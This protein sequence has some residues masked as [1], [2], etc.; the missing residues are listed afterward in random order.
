[1]SLSAVT[2]M[3][4]LKNTKVVKSWIEDYG[5]KA[6]RTR[7]ISEKWERGKEVDLRQYIIRMNHLMDWLEKNQDRWDSRR[8]PPYGLGIEPQWLVQKRARDEKSTPL[9]RFWTDYE[10]QYLAMQVGRGIPY[11]Q[12]AKDL[13][14][15]LKSVKSKGHELGLVSG[16]GF[17]KKTA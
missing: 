12:V 8:V 1:M 11:S 17:Q 14:R 6:T 5:L 3:M 10:K 13:S 16:G 9:Y 15:S 7:M 2:D 4:G